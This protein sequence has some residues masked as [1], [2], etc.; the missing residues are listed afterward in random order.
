MKS[1]ALKIVIGAALATGFA[2]TTT[3]GGK[4]LTGMS[5]NIAQT[6]QGLSRI[7]GFRKLKTDTVQAEAAWMSAQKRVTA[8]AREI[9]A[10]DKPTKEM[11]RNM[12]AAKREASAAKTSYNRQAQSLQ[13]LRNDMAA[14][15]QSTRGLASQNRDLARTYERLTVQQ[16]RLATLTTARDDNLAK[17]SEIRGKM[18]GAAIMAATVA[19][20][21]KM[22]QNFESSMADVKKVVNFDDGEEGAAQFKLMRSEILKM[23]TQLPMAASGI[24]DIYAAAGRAGIARNELGGFAK[25]AIK[26]SIA[27]DMSA[28]SAA[29]AMT[30]FRKIFDLPQAEVVRLGDAINYLDNNMDAT[31]GGITRIMQRSGAMAKVFGLTAEENAALA[32]TFLELKVP[33]EVA[34][35]GM[36][37]MFNRLATAEEQ[38]AK[39]QEGLDAIGFSASQMKAMI[40]T[41]A[42]GAL[43][44][45][46]DAVDGSEDKLAILSNMFGLEYGDDM[47]RLVG[48]L[49]SLKNAF[50]LVADEQAHLNSMNK[51]YEVRAATSANNTTIFRNRVSRLAVNLGTV[52]L[53][54]VNMV[55]GGLG[56]VTDVLAVAADRFPLLTT[57][58]VGGAAALVT[59][60]VVTLA[61]AYA[62][63]FMT[64]AVLSAKIQMV[65]FRAWVIATN[66]S[67]RS[68]NVTSLVTAAR[69]RLLAAGGMIKAFAGSLMTLAR[70]AIPA[71]ITGMRA[72]TVAMLFNPIGFIIT[73]IALG[74]ALIVKFWTPISGFFKSLWGKVAGPAQGAFRVLKTIFAWS[75]LGL[76]A[77]GIG[78][79]ARFIAAAF[80]SPLTLVKGIWSGFKRVM[81]WS[82]VAAIKGA[83][84]VLPSVFKGVFDVV[85]TIVK[86]AM[87]G[88]TN[89]LMGP[90]KL[91]EGLWNKLK[92]LGRATKAAASRAAAP[93]KPALKAGA[94]TAAAIILPAPALAAPA[95]DAV[96]PAAGAITLASPDVIIPAP[97]A[98]DSPDIAV[99]AQDILAPSAFAVPEFAASG[100]APDFIAPSAFAADDADDAAG[101]KD[102]GSVI[103]HVQPSDSSPRHNNIPPPDDKRPPAPPPPGDIHIHLTL[104]NVFGDARSLVEHLR[105]EL[106]RAMKEARDANLHD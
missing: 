96:L 73:G 2:A 41:D 67:M 32:A 11:T 84:S 98:L 70:F 80:L 78:A 72:L 42:K 71:V 34:G 86:L 79:G 82:P 6:Q 21:V 14:A 75:P 90:I 77:R 93:L 101:P 24:T 95:P 25:D 45:F 97:I 7:D 59:L 15:G 37:A 39:F 46:L 36:N 27:F 105:P 16:A 19:A 13:T 81:S 47:V 26:M 18:V 51:E 9:K 62:K 57:V 1:L 92:G 61:Y 40:E 55:M 17:R 35:T 10:A 3:Q 74:A 22:A 4:L 30:G 43:I 99:P 85:K 38:G 76:L 102:G 63:T 8:L 20:P 5:Q 53:P 106:E 49:G 87:K 48:G 104:N 88:L 23:S 66:L 60:R 44:E 58:I 29:S 54:A 50:G 83:W 89:F 28:E 103:V 52:L 33:V 56:A 91:V 69:F 100:T 31:A 65:S 68:L 12:A 64:G 94:A